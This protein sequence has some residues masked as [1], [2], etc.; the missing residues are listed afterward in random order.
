M[1]HLKSL[2]RDIFG[3]RMMIFDLAKSDFRKR[4]VGSYFG[5]VWMFVQPLVTVA[6]YA[7][8]FG[9]YGFKSAPPVPDTSYVI[10]LIPGLV[11]WFFFSEA[12][13]MITGIL[14]EYNYLVKKVVFPVELLPI[15]KLASCFLVHL[16]FI[17]IMLVAF[18]ISGKVPEVSW[19]QI[20]Y[21]SF[22]ASVL[23]LGLGYLTSAVNVFFKD[24][25]Q[26][27]GIVL[28][29]GIWMCPIMYDETLF[30]SRA[31]WIGTALKLNPFYY[32]VAGYRDSML[33]GDPFW[34]RPTLGVYYWVFTLAVFF[35]GLGF[36][37]RLRPHFSDVL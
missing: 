18:L 3:R 19:I 2:I 14:H 6:I 25:Q 16:C 9:P 23:A 11:P 20:F 8:I 21:Y 1:N 17:A 4:F 30:T 15:I 29:F 34:M 32:I 10:W 26:I 28:Q 37:K 27:V 13:N 33:T 5:I 22:A 7:F 12:M 36:F 35:V 31:P 24:M